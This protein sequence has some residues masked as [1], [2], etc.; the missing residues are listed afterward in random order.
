MESTL[1]P[2]WLSHPQLT[3][4]IELIV[5]SL[6]PSGQGEFNQLTWNRLRGCSAAMILGL[7]SCHSSS[8]SSDNNT[9]V[10]PVLTGRRWG[11]YMPY[12][13]QQ[14]EYRRSCDYS[15][16]P[17]WTAD[18]TWFASLLNKESRKDQ[19][20][21]CN[22][23]NSGIVAIK[24][25]FVWCHQ[26]WFWPPDESKSKSIFRSNLF[27]LCWSA[28]HTFHLHYTHTHTLC[29]LHTLSIFNLILHCS[30]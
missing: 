21:G 23:P 7:W 1:C 28:L 24:C 8:A 6:H 4:S 22:K 11:L 17:E 16:G 12:E 9:S 10:D 3:E 20:I 30:H 13:Q 25:V 18:I 27:T 2:L 26:Q 5:I 29:I 14:L 15:S 19:H